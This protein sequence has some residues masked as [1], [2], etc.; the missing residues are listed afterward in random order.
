MEPYFEFRVVV[1]LNSLSGSRVSS[2][3]GCVCRSVLIMLNTG[4]MFQSVPCIC[5]LRQAEVQE[6]V[7]EVRLDAGCWMLGLWT[8]SPPSSS[9]P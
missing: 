9:D 2:N 6:D 3:V 4:S 7:P 1:H 8:A 5:S